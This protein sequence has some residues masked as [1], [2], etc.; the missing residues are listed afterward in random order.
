MPGKYT[1][2]GNAYNWP[3]AAT[4]DLEMNSAEMGEYIS[5]MIAELE[6]RERH[7]AHM[8]ASNRSRPASLQSGSQPMHSMQQA[9][10]SA[11]NIYANQMYLNHGYQ[12]GPTYLVAGPQSMMPQAT[13]PTPHAAPLAQDGQNLYT[14]RQA[15]PQEPIDLTGDDDDFATGTPAPQRPSTKRVRSDSTFGAATPRVKKGRVEKPKV[16]KKPRKEKKVKTPKIPNS[17]LRL[18]T[19][20]AATVAPSYD[21]SFQ[22]QGEPLAEQQQQQHGL[23]SAVQTQFFSN[24]VDLTFD[25]PEW[26]PTDSVISGL[27]LDEDAQQ[28]QQQQ[29]H[30]LSAAVENQSSSNAVDLTFDDQEVDENEYVPSDDAKKFAAAFCA[31]TALDYEVD[32]LDAFEPKWRTCI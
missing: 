17:G 26:S 16:E 1:A 27:G 2:W 30:D 3:P 15:A 18:P 11:S 29:Q 8:M 14:A 5:D 9:A 32:M 31:G 12:A 24:A 4:L 28:Q 20:A 25:A 6:W 7:L 23:P 10:P 22:V 13:S 19:F 21:N